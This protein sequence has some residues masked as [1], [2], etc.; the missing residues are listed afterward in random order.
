MF[1]LLRV[2]APTPVGH[3]IAVM[4]GSDIPD[5]EYRK[6]TVKLG[7]TAVL[8]ST[9]KVMK[10]QKFMSFLASMGLRRYDIVAVGAYLDDQYKSTPWGWRALRR[11]GSP[12]STD[13]RRMYEGHYVAADG[14][15]DNTITRW[16]KK[17]NGCRIGG[18]DTA[19]YSKPVPYPVLL[20]VDRISTEFPD[21]G[22]W[23]SDEA[24]V[25]KDVVKD[26]FLLVDYAGENFIIEKWDEPTFKG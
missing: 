19:L 3:P 25:L 18:Y 2:P 1:G 21:A 7:V 16:G 23:V 26:P 10:Q 5:D 12:I 9:D 24:I 4:D 17:H 15:Y 13:G 20:T 14:T 11:Q 8:Q 6:L 22:F